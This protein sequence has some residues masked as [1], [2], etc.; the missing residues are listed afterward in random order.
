MLIKR[1]Y[2]KNKRCL[3]EIGE[4]MARNTQTKQRIKETFTKLINEK[5]LDALT[6]S[7]IARDSGI[8]RGTFYLHYLDKYDLMAQLENETIENLK[9]IILVDHEDEELDDPTDLVS[10]SAIYAALRYV[11][12]DF[13]F[14]K[15]LASDGGDP[16][17]MR[18]FKGIMDDLLM[19]KIT[20]SKEIHFFNQNMPDDYAR[21]ILL[22]NIVAIISLWIKKDGLESPELIAKMVT[23]AKQLSPYE[24]IA[25][26]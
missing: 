16:H 20:E 22:S 23:K 17:F 14:I 10:Y 9:Q 1:V 4:L 18:M 11:K 15:A 13:A 21:E 24:L 19:T 2:R 3:D 25:K 6:V 7:D 8:N 12:N 5:G 26:N